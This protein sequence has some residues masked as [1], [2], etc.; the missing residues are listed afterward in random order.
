ME[1]V[2]SKFSLM[3]LIV[4]TGGPCSGKTT[5]IERVRSWLISFSKRKVFVIPEVARIIFG[6][7]VQWNMLDNQQSKYL[8]G[9]LIRMFFTDSFL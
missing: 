9:H 6:T 8:S 2:K 3:I 5:L 4:F 7:S 1:I